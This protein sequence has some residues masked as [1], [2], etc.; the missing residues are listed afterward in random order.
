MT[1]R[2]AS[3]MLEVCTNLQDSLYSHNATSRTD[4]TVTTTTRDRQRDANAPSQEFYVYDGFLLDLALDLGN[5]LL[6]AFDTPTGI[7][8]GTVNLM[9]GVPSGETPVASLAGGGTL[10]LEFHLLSKLTNDE[11]FGRAAK[12]A[13]RA[14]FG[15]HSTISRLY[16]KHST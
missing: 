6:L 15:R 4:R 2:D 12:L 3:E 7:P 14:L 13:T 5:R 11:R 10:S 8:Y 1:D 16:G 9:H